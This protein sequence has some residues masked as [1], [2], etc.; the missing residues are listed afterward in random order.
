M[1]RFKILFIVLLYDTY[2]RYEVRGELLANLEAQVRHAVLERGEEPAGLAQEHG[3]TVLAEE[4]DLVPLRA[5]QF[6]LGFREQIP[7][8]DRLHEACV[9]QKNNQNQNVKAVAAIFFD[10]LPMTTVRRDCFRA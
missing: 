6:V 2:F 9:G 3:E 1:K 7:D 10:S 5:A 8:L 4:D